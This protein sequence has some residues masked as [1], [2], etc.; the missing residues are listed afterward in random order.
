MQKLHHRAL[1]ISAFALLIAVAINTA[2][3]IS[4]TTAPSSRTPEAIGADL[5]QTIASLQG[6]LQDSKVFESSDARKK[7]EPDAL[8][9]IH[10][11][12]ALFDEMATA[13]P[14]AKQ[15][16]DASAPQF[17][18][19]A[20]FFDDPDQ[21]SAAQK[22]AGGNDLP[23][24]Q[25]KAEIA[26]ADYLKASDDPARNKAL[27][28]FDAAIKLHPDDPGMVGLVTMTSIAPT[29][30]VDV[31]THLLNIVKNDAQGS[32]AQQLAQEM[33]SNLKQ[34]Q[35][36]NKPL[37]IQGT[38]ITGT[39]LSTESWKGKVILVDF[40]ATWCGPCRAELPR[41]KQIYSKYHDQGLEILGV[42]CDNAADDLKN[43]LAQNPDMPW[44]QIFDQK[45]PGWSPIATGFGI[46]AI[47]TMFLIDRKGI[48]RTVEAR[49]QMEDLIPKLLAEK[50]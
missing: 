34:R 32:D 24:A 11:L 35:L 8:N 15:Q 42:S 31:Y 7:A 13:A 41:V 2:P 28:S 16:L 36:E 46:E 40:W 23:A 29:P 9:S 14:N 3:T 22:L 26:I 6:T 48:L 45:N 50:P 20:M 18:V 1:L 30:S 49:E 21:T 43:F 39:N 4:Q 33:D 19:L 38:T 44:P 17:R 25:A 47:P 12:F 10:K 37:V 27:D 5:S